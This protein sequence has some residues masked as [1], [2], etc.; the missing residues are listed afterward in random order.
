MDV[1]LDSLNT[2]CDW[3]VCGVHGG[4]GR[5]AAC[6]VCQDIRDSGPDTV[7]REN[8]AQPHGSPRNLVVGGGASVSIG[9]EAEALCSL[10]AAG[11]DARILG[12]KGPALL[13]GA[14]HSFESVVPEGVVSDRAGEHTGHQPGESTRTSS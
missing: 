1:P 3:T 14:Y 2:F 5:E 4:G 6:G 13:G 7:N 11:Q 10:G 12:Q 8:Q 9:C